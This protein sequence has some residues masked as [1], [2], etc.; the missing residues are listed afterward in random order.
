MKLSVI[1]PVY[2]LQDFIGD[3]L[4]SLLS[5]EVDFEYELIV[6]NDCST[7]SSLSV[8]KTYQEK[9]PSKIKLINNIVNQ[10]LAKN[11]KLLLQ[12]ASGHYIAYMDGDD[13]ALPGKLQT[14]VDYL[15]THPECSMVY[16]ESEVFDSET[17]Q[18]MGFYVRD[19]YNRSYIPEHASIEH[20]VRYGSFFQAS[21]LMFKRHEHLMN[22]VDERCQ[23]IL[24]QPFQILNAGYTGGKIGR[25]NEVLGRYRIHANSFGAN[26]L[27]DTSR[28]LQVL[29][30]QLF[31][32]N[33]AE[34]FAMDSKHIEAGKSHYYFATALFYLKLGQRQLFKQHIDLSKENGVFFDERHKHLV[35]NSNNF[36]YCVAY[37]KRE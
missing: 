7:D 19:Y 20:L 14:Q 35:E 22:T 28:R 17:D 33:N 9:Y 1:I 27:Q 25:I 26:T 6:A 34:K 11:M 31:A 5:Q 10:R 18:S 8:I 15:D 23:I 4:S 21:S 16:H 12:K 2:N 3:C 37:F 29:Q 13:L 24:D 36:E 32:I 30:D